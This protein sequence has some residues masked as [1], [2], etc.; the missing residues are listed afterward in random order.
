[1]SKGW[2]FEPG[3]HSLASRGISTS[4]E[5][6]LKKWQERFSDEHIPTL[7]NEEEFKDGINHLLESEG[8]L[9][10]VEFETILRDMV[11]KFQNQIGM[12]D[13]VP[14]NVVRFGLDE[15]YPA[16]QLE[17]ASDGYARI[18]VDGPFYNQL[19]K[20]DFDK[21]YEHLEFIL[22]HELAHYIQWQEYDW[23]YYKD[24]YPEADLD[25][26]MF[27]E[28]MSGISGE[29]CDELEDRYYD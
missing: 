7:K 2:R 12:G 26:D 20:Y 29:E 23:D 1:M 8:Y 4:Q 25:A 18:Y 17:T 11:Y 27:A 10:P 3:R 24:R 6:R 21:A 19:F 9:K 5:K 14:V 13:R 16:G 28:Q 15:G 22:F